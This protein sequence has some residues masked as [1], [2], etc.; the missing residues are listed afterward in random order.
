MAST[1]LERSAISQ[2]LRS[3]VV[4]SSIYRNVAAPGHVCRRKR[5]SMVFAPLFA[6]AFARGRRLLRLARA[7]AAHAEKVCRPKS[8]AVCS[9]IWSRVRG[10][11]PVVAETVVLWHVSC[12]DSVCARVGGWRTEI[13]SR[14]TCRALFV[15]WIRWV[16]SCHGPHAVNIREIVFFWLSLSDCDGW[17]GDLRVSCPKGARNGYLIQTSR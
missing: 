16:W 7:Y 2:H 3:W 14:I 6:R 5:P 13:R 8:C 10:V 9:N 12:A 15:H 17:R 11:T 1:A 4:S